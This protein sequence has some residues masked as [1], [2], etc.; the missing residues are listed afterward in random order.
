MLGMTEPRTFSM[1]IEA[2]LDMRVD[3]PERLAD[4]NQVQAYDLPIDPSDWHKLTPEVLRNVENALVAVTGLPV[5]Q[6][7]SAVSIPGVTLTVTG[8][9]VTGP[10]RG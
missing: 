6:A 3:D 5:I 10:A 4:A 9:K 7:L 2:K 1:S 8:L